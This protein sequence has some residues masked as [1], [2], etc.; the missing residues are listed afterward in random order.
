MPEHRESPRDLREDEL[1]RA[2]RDLG[3]RLAYPEPPDLAAVTRRLPYS[4]VPL[5][6]PPWARRGVLRRPTARLRRT[7]LALAAALTFVAT[8]VAVASPAA[9]E[10]VAGWLGLPGAR[11]E[12]TPSPP[13][14]PTR[15]LGE[16]LRLGERVTLEEARARV[17][18]PILVPD[19]PA[20]GA[21]DEV[22]VTSEFPGGQV[23]LVY[24][25]RAGMP[26][27]AETGAAVLV[28]EFAGDLE[29]E[30]LRKTIGPGSELEAVNV[31]GRRGFWIEGAPHEVFLLDRHGRPIPDTLRLS[32]NVL[33][34]ERGGVTLRLESALGKQ[35]ALDIASSF[36]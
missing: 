36:R 34:W 16:G 27:A 12:L 26:S 10:A 7:V 32:G 31:N 28:S 9:R 24:G 8:A 20:L 2:L 11:I 6:T 23:F 21:P 18:F 35:D 13:T 22:Y 33:L 15:T 30:I 1:E 19:D 4:P 17:A 5:P 3:A 29:R 14:A 25:E